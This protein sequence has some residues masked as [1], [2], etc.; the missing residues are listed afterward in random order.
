MRRWLAEGRLWISPE[1]AVAIIEAR[2]GT[3]TGH[4]QKL[5]ADARASGE[6]RYG[7]DDR[8]QRPQYVYAYRQDD[9]EGWLQRLLIAHGELFPKAPVA[10]PKAGRGPKP[11]LF[12]RT[13]AAMEKDITAGKL[14]VADINYKVLMHRYGACRDLI[15]KALDHISNSR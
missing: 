13:V 12:D 2:L 9:L 5:L 1:A 11:K 8:E 4:A 6:V 7:D 10:K 15:R 14:K 3:T